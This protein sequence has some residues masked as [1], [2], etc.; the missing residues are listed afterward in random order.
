MTVQ[1][2]VI[3][4]AFKDFRFPP[5][6]KGEK[7]NLSIELSVYLTGL[8]PIDSIDQFH[9]GRH[10]I[11]VRWGRRASTF[12][13]KVAVE[14]GWNRVRTLEH[15]GLKAGLGSNAWMD[16]NARFFI[17]ETQVIREKPKSGSPT[18]E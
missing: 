8:V 2:M 9:L 18:T 15:L 12:L 5:L 13:P 14:Q 6:T 10:G 7:K 3:S 16:E 11:L 4:S 1:R 17:Y